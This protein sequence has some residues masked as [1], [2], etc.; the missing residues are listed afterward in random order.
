[1]DRDILYRFMRPGEENEIHELIAGVFNEFIGCHYPPEGVREFFDYI[2]PS[3]LRERFLSNHFT[4]VAIQDGRIV[5][6]IEVRDQ[7]HVCLFFVDA[8]LH[9][10]GI[11]RGLF[12]RAL[13]RCRQNRPDSTYVDVNSSPNAVRIYERLGFNATGPET[14]ING[15]T[16]VPMVFEIEKDKRN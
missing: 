15:I 2:G 16:F 14:T 9:G 7:S 4:L 3:S 8:H 5:G 6:V 10:H 1:L 13:E 12:E 11:G